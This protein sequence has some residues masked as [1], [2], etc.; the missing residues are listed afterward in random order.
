[1]ENVISQNQ[2]IE[3][4][5]ENENAMA[6]LY[7]DYAKKFLLFKDFWKHISE[8]EYS[9]AAWINT[10]HG[11]MKAKTVD[12]SLNRF[13]VDA[14]RQ[15]IEYIK[16]KQRE[17]SEGDMA[18]LDA[19]ETSVHLEKGLLENKYFEVFKDDSLELQIVLEA[20]KLSTQQ[21]LRDV[22]RK[23]QEEKFGADFEKLTA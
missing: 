7:A 6:E 19:L 9:H 14:I 12:F 3:M 21:H 2:I 11:K 17:V 23:W 5:V 1:M 8:D 10:L 15:N 4:L 18:L 16:T 20:L 13:P 22:T